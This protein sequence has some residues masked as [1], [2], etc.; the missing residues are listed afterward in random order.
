MKFSQKNAHWSIPWFAI[1][2]IGVFALSIVLH[3]WGLGRFNTLV[4]DEIYYVKY[5]N[6]YL[7]HTPLFDA[8]PPMGKY[9]IA[10]G[11]WIG[12][13]VLGKDSPSSLAGTAIYPVVYRWMNAFTGSLLPMVVGGIA[14]QLSHRRSFAFI[15]S[16][17][18]AVDGLF[19]VESRYALIN[20]YLVMFGLLGQWF[21]LIALN[22]RNRRQFWL[23]I[24]GI[25]FGASAAVKWNALGFLLGV[26]LVWISAWVMEL[27]FDKRNDR[28][29]NRSQFNNT[30]IERGNKEQYKEHT[31]QKLTQLN[32]FHILLNL[33][34]IPAIV[35]CL[36][37]IP[38][39]QINTNA[40]LGKVHQQMLG[41]HQGMANG[42][43]VH[44]YCS[45][46][47][48][49]L[50]TIRPVVYLYENATSTSRSA[51]SLPPLPAGTQKVIFAVYGMGN[52]ILWW[53]STLAI[54]LLLGLLIKR[55]W[56]WIKTSLN[57]DEISGDNLISQIRRFPQTKE[58]WIV[59]YL[60]VNWLAHVLPWTKVTR[61]TFIYL[62][63]SAAVF[64]ILGLAWL[65]DRWLQSY[66]NRLR[67]MG[68]TAIFLILAAFVF[69][70]PIYLGLPMSS[71]EFQMRIWLKTWI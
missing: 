13:H 53:L 24:S 23:S 59:F 31:L 45:N 32:L 4:F 5:A 33:V 29:G 49:W 41:F 27:L 12:S 58:L 48:T 37:W 40:G 42:P 54:L 36:I 21:F 6:N 16:L 67:A 47:Y 63:M 38:H 44:P 20:I 50:L 28:P 39:L 2:M 64:A 60:V 3:F 10:L 34:I 9:M 17:F 11:M 65:I 7:T 70:L 43:K 18:M 25:C 15:A 14:Y 68:I 56:G 55:V 19:L 46:W 30:V 61:C 57:D 69:W 52:P 62:Y 71:E 26:Y 8:H 1:G 51:L 66:Q 35:Y 22:G